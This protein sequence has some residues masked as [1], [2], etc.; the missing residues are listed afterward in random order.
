[1][2][3]ERPAVRAIA[4]REVFP[5]LR[6]LQVFRMA[7]RPRVL[8][9]AIVAALFCTTGWRVIG[10]MFQGSDDPQIAFDA[11]EGKR[12]YGPIARL[13]TRWPWEPLGYDLWDVT[14]IPRQSNTP[15]PSELAQSVIRWEELNERVTATDPSIF[16]SFLSARPVR[17]IIG[18]R[19]LFEPTATAVRTAFLA[20]CLLW[21]IIVW[22][23]AG[24]LITR[25]A[26]V[27]FARGEQIAWNRAHQFAWKKWPS[28]FASPMLPILGVVIIALFMALFGLIL[29]IP[30]VGIPLIAVT[31]PLFLVGGLLMAILLL[32]LV[33]GWPLMW[34][35]V[36][37]E[38]TDSFD[39]LGRSY[40]YVFG[41]PLRYLGYA[42]V[43]LM[44][45]WLGWIVV[46]IFAELVVDTTQWAA[47]WG[48][49]RT[50]MELVASLARASGELPEG[51]TGFDAWSAKL[52]EFFNGCVRSIPIAFLYGFFWCAAVMIYL[53]LRRDEDQTEIDEVFLE[54]EQETY[55]MPPLKTDAA[56][57]SQPADVPPPPKPAADKPPAGKSPAEEKSSAGDKPIGEN[58]NGPLPLE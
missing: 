10:A 22:A 56:G 50:R 33:V 15:D 41:K 53:L 57:V 4:W 52:I 21:A 29:R 43:A 2:S 23:F 9:V 37:C 27:G 46:D 20:L 51:T 40:G 26:A 49:G 12:E 28:F 38:G 13:Y 30:Y 1:M 55:G 14:D 7:I 47:S 16:S 58:D 36:S 39:A 34:C 24:G 54:D 31:W 19:E 42:V 18:F 11:G 25:I 35:T 6:L 5:W 48:S 17:Q 45:G 3:E 32:G 8:M 44:L